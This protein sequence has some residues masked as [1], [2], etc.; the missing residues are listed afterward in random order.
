MITCRL[1][2]SINIWIECCLVV[3]LLGCANQMPNSDQSAKS[4]P[5]GLYEVIERE[6][7]YSSGVPEDCSRTQYIEIVKGVFYGI[8]KNETA[9]V[10]WLAENSAHQHEYSARDLRRGLFVNAHEFIVEDDAFGKEWFVIRNG[11]ITDYYFIRHNRQ[12]PH[13]DL[14]GRTHLVLRKI[15]RGVKING[16]LPYPVENE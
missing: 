4:L 7:Q 13:G 6:C 14:A 9:L 15:P 8:G 3:I 5:L 16:L 10:T 12:N 11:A 2:H 1:I